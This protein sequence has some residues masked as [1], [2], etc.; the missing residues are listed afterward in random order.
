[1]RVSGEPAR[2]IGEVKGFK[3]RVRHPSTLRQARSDAAQNS[4]TA[5]WPKPGTTRVLI[6]GLNSSCRVEWRSGRPF[7]W[8]G[9][10]GTKV[11]RVCCRRRPIGRGQVSRRS[12]RQ[13]VHPARLSIAP[14]R[15]DL[16]ARV[17]GKA[18]AVQF[19][20]V[21]R[22]YDPRCGAGVVGAALIQSLL[23]GSATSPLTSGNRSIDARCALAGY[24]AGAADSVDA[25]GRR[26][27]LRDRSHAVGDPF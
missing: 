8:L 15:S 19:V 3:A 12:W 10:T 2:S 23:L 6:G 5:F 25:A 13:T 4:T 20:S 22:G 14:L 11:K 9:G 18:R 7:H 24:R 26:L 21:D 27:C 1:M 16:Q 17:T